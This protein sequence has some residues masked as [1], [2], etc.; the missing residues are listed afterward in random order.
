MKRILLLISLLPMFVFSQSISLKSDLEKPSYFINNQQVDLNKIYS[1]LDS[2]NIKSIDV[3]KFKN[4][5]V[6]IKLKKPV[7]F[8]TVSSL[9]SNQKERLLY[10]IDENVIKNPSEILIDKNS[11][12]DVK[13]IDNYTIDGNTE[14]FKILKI[15]TKSS[16]KNKVADNS[17]SQINSALVLN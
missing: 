8:V 13:L 2:N 14:T 16:L 5:E 17:T 7:N 3:A 1:G 10:F 15:S 4:G 12:T 11:V 9:H 6:H